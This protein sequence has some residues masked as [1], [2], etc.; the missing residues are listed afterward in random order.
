MLIE[1]N[2]SAYD[3]ALPFTDLLNDAMVLP[4]FDGGNVGIRRRALQKLFT[5][6]GYKPWATCYE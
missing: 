2:R 3:L 1:E 6:E 4:I 5:S